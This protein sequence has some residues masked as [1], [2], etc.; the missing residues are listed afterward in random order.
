VMKRLQAKVDPL[1]AKA[2]DSER[3]MCRGLLAAAPAKG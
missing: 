1:C 3:E 2:A